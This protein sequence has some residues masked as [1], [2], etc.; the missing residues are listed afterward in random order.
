MGHKVV[1][2]YSFAFAIQQATK[3]CT[4]NNMQNQPM[5][6][7]FIVTFTNLTLFAL[8]SMLS[9]VYIEYNYL[10]ISPNSGDK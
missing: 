10:E 7:V 1:Y 8:L 5:I 4:F 2:M 3:S 6:F 9:F